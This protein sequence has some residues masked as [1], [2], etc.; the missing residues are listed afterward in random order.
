MN[1]ITDGLTL[2]TV[3]GGLF[4]F[5]KWI[6]ERKDL[7]TKTDIDVLERINKDKIF[8]ENNNLILKRVYSDKLSYLNKFKK[9]EIREF[10]FNTNNT[11]YIDNLYI[12]SDLSN[13][14]LITLNTDINKFIRTDKS[15]KFYYKTWF[16][17]LVIFLVILYATFLVGIFAFYVQNLNEILKWITLVILVAIVEIPV[18]IY[19]SNIKYLNDFDNNIS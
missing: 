5:F 3:I 17:W 14:N 15:N 11:S 13:K 12:L 18:L 8:S 2:L 1:N 7:K 16:K 19:M 6:I 9:I 10:I 4:A